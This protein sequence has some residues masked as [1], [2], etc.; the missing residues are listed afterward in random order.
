M[1]VE[2]KYPGEW[3]SWVKE[4]EWRGAP[5]LMRWV[6]RVVKTAGGAAAIL[7]LVTLAVDGWDWPNPGAMWVA[8][9]G[10]AAYAAWEFLRA[11]R[12]DRPGGFTAGEIWIGLAGYC[13]LA[14]FS[15]ALLCGFLDRNILPKLFGDGWEICELTGLWRGAWLLAGAVAVVLTWNVCV[16]AMSSLRGEVAEVDKFFAGISRW[17]AGRSWM[18]QRQ[19]E[20]AACEWSDTRRAYFFNW[21]FHLLPRRLSWLR[22]EEINTCYGMRS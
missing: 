15:V 17:T 19:A 13:A 11:F 6:R 7:I 18:P 4:D 12:R 1:L 20:I 16:W 14:F 10:L 21:K 9:L 5:E 3:N 2:E 22:G 8:G